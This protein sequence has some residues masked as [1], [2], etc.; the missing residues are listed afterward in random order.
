MRNPDVVQNVE[1]GGRKSFRVGTAGP[2]LNYLPIFIF[3]LLILPKQ[4]C[5]LAFQIFSNQ[6][7]HPFSVLRQNPVLIPYSS[8]PIFFFLFFL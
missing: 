2:T 4:L 5:K 8:A 3:Q 6:S 1:V 7:R